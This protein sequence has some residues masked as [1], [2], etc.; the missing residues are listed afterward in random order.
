MTETLPS[1]DWDFAERELAALLRTR[2][3]ALPRQVPPPL[4][5]VVDRGISTTDHFSRDGRRAFWLV[6]A[7]LIA[8]VGLGVFSQRNNDS[9]PL[10]AV[11]ISGEINEPVEYIVRVKVDASTE[12]IAAITAVIEG[13]SAIDSFTYVDRD[14]TYAEFV[15]YWR[16][17]PEVPGG[18]TADQLPTSFRVQAN[19]HDAV[20]ELARLD[21]VQDVGRPVVRFDELS[22]AADEAT[23]LVFAAGG[24]PECNSVLP[25]VMT[26]LAAQGNVRV[27]GVSVLTPDD[28]IAPDDIWVA[29]AWPYAIAW[30]YDG[31]FTRPI[32]IEAFPSVAL[33]SPGGI[34]GEALVGDNITADNIAKLLAE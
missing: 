31:D 28:V 21:G 9:D 13:S 20:I 1:P 33:W 19:N 6:A 16:D 7:A 25:G 23:V 5:S 32:G 22:F 30:L 12:Q 18:V 24:C 2:A 15:D 34:V 14:A 8:V 3:D 4:S 10:T 17:R 26:D 29:S 11:P 27:V